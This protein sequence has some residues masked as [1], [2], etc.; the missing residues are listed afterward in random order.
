M[1]RELPGIS[2]YTLARDPRCGERARRVLDGARGAAMA[3]TRWRL[4]Q[5]LREDVALAH[6]ERRT[7]HARDFPTPSDLTAEERAVYHAA[8]T[9]YLVLFGEIPACTVEPARRVEIDGAGLEL[10]DRPGIFVDT[11][12]GTELRVLRF[13]GAAPQASDS[14]R[15]AT[16]L[17]A[18]D[19]LLP[20]R[21]VLADLL[22][23]ETATITV[24]ASD[25]PPAR[26]W[27][28]ERVD[29]WRDAASG[30]PANHGGCLYCEFVWD[31]RVHRGRG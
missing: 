19:E 8:A 15:H 7:P 23:L 5:R 18:G 11:D 17:V 20:V 27:V 2:T 30:P 16:A 12:E 4:G 24:T 14:L 28:N 31:C 21:V 25:I 3:R 6:A 26:E 10:T 29:V 22:S 13:S 9:G 1:D